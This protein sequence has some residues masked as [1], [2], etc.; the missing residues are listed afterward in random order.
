MAKKE[1]KT[2]ALQGERLFNIM[3]P[4]YQGVH[5][6]SE[7]SMKGDKSLATPI[8]GQGWV[9]NGTSSI[10]YETYVDLSSLELDDLTLV[11]IDAGIQ[12]PGI[13]TESRG[14]SAMWV[15]D[16]MSQQRLN[17]NTITNMLT[18]TLNEWNNAPGMAG[19]DVD[20]TMI[21]MGNLR[22]MFKSS[23]SNQF[24]TQFTSPFGSGDPVVVQKLW[25]YRFIFYAG[26]STETLDIPASRFIL[27]ANI[28]DEKKYVYIQR[29]K[30]SYELQGL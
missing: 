20:Y 27:R 25:C 28:T 12:D 9:A 16:I 21:T 7:W 11:P 13:Y 1:R 22:V 3:I 6:G 18:N 8:D 26:A 24:I 17:A 10:Y 30:T 29:L 14:D 2:R 19:H 4:S 15:M 23:L 5:D